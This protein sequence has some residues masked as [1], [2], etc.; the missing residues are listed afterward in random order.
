MR[1]SGED[2]AEPQQPRQGRRRE[3]LEVGHVT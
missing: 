2:V 3:L 1:V